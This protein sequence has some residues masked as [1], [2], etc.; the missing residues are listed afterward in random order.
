MWS[1]HLLRGGQVIADR[2]TLVDVLG[3]MLGYLGRLEVIK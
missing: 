3:V 2:V 1:L